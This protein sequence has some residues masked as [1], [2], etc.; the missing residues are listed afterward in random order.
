MFK[1]SNA[2]KDTY[3]TNVIINDT[4]MTGSNVGKASTLDLFKITGK[5]IDDVPVTELSRLLIKFD[6]S[7]LKELYSNESINIDTPTFFSK[8]TLYD[9]YNAN[10]AIKDFSIRINPLAVSFEE[11]YG[12]DI[13][14]FTDQDESNFLFSSSGS[15]WDSEGCNTPSVDYISGSY[16]KNVS[17]DSYSQNLTIDVTDI[18]RDIIKGIIPDEGFRISFSNV[19]ESSNKTLFVKRFASSQ[20]LNKLKRPQLHWGMNDSY[21]SAHN[22]IVLG[23]QH[24]LFLT[25]YGLTGKNNIF[26]NNAEI[27]GSD[28]ILLQLKIKN[29][30]SYSYDF[31]AGSS[32]IAGL[33]MNGLYSASLYIDESDEVFNEFTKEND[34]TELTLIPV[35]SVNSSSIALLTGSHITCRKP[36][37]IFNTYAYDGIH[38]SI[39]NNKSEYDS[40][41]I[42]MLNVNILDYSTPYVNAVRKSV[43][44]EALLSH[45]YISSAHYQVKEYLSKHPCIP[46]DYEFNSTSLSFDNGKWFFELDMSNLYPGYQY[47]I[48]ISVNTINGVKTFSNVVIFKVKQ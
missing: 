40:N 24:K 13:A 39:E 42:S 30:E 17:I 44:I 28:C 36:S 10:S 35:W 20:T 38:V 15:L 6:L 5:S 25:N 8:I 14:K 1:T 32:E 27:S 12:H 34:L 11:G 3:I 26:I 46:F 37:R 18:I 41:E 9:V 45:T 22:E 2:L 29:S 33:Q 7:E 31:L 4:Q 21:I 23:S 19:D 43:N 48:D 16:E 47:S